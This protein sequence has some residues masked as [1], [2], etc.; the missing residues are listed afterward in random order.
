M[1][2]NTYFYFERQ[3]IGKKSITDI[4]GLEHY[5]KEFHNTGYEKAYHL[6]GQYL[7]FNQDNE[8][9]NKWLMQEFPSINTKNRLLCIDAL[10]QWTRNNL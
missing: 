4:P 7:L 5:G 8:L 6:L 2:N 10:S 1:N 3:P 9:F